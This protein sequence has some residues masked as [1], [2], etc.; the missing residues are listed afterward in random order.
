MSQ[1]SMSALEYSGNCNFDFNIILLKLLFQICH[2]D[3]SFG[4]V[5]NDQLDCIC[6]CIL[7]LNSK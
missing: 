5:K 4:Y 2:N 3:I 7:N 1:M 6:S